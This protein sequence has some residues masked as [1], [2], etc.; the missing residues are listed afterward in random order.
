MASVPQNISVLIPDGETTLLSNV[1]YS[2]SLIKHVKIYVLSSHKRRYLKYSIDN[3]CFKYSRFIEAFIY[4]ENTTTEGWINKIDATVEDYDID[5]I[6]PIFDLSTKRILEHRNNLKHKSKLCC[7]SH[8]TNFET[9]L[10]KDLLYKFLKSKNLPCPQSIIVDKDSKFDTTA[11]NFPVVGKPSFGFQGGMRV[12][13]LNNNNELTKYIS[14]TKTDYPILLQQFIEGFDVSCNV[15]C[16][17]GEIL[18]YTMQKA[19]MQE[20]VKVTPQ[21]EFSFFHDDALLALMKTLM[22][23]LNWCGVANIDFRYDNTDNSY[24]VIEINPRFWLNTEASAI[25]GVNFPYLYCLLSLN[26]T[27]EFTPV[28]TGT[29]LHLKALVKH[30]KRYPFL[31]FKFNYLHNHTPLRFVIKDPLVVF[32]KFLWRT[33][34]KVSSKVLKTKTS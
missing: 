19:V 21:H 29:F 7:L 34:N 20:T 8:I 13:L 27:I 10:R 1:V 32:C 28:K 3:S 33:N 23:A 6:M 25:A 26:K 2:F 16:N 11:L 31:I 15:L 30:L 9:A 12:S 4:Y 24:K 18:A 5:L 14:T 22:K 17:N